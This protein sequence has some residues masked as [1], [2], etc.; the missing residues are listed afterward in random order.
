MV[1]IPVSEAFFSLFLKAYLEL[2][3]FISSLYYTGKDEKNFAV[4]HDTSVSKQLQGRPLGRG[5]RIFSSG[6][7]SV[8]SPIAPHYLFEYRR[9]LYIWLTII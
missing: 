1:V 8:A 5:G 7:E 4:L 3:F 2:V 9:P 6:V